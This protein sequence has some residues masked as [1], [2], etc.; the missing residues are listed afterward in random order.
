MSNTNR[1]AEIATVITWNTETIITII[2]N[3]EERV[4]NTRE[5]RTMDLLNKKS[6]I[7]RKILIILIIVIV[8]RTFRGKRRSLR[9]RGRIWIKMRR[10]QI[11]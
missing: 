8:E 11:K 7:M 2:D 5:T 9:I 3:R 6:R 1:L 4:I 10:P